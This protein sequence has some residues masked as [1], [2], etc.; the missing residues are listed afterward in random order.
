MFKGKSVLFCLVVALVG[1][2]VAVVDIVSSGIVD[3]TKSSARSGHLPA[4][5]SAPAGPCTITY[6]N[7]AAVITACPAGDGTALTGTD[8]ASDVQITVTVRDSNC[9][10][11]AGMPPEDIWLVGCNPDALLLCGASIC[12]SADHATDQ[13]GVTTISNS[14]RFGGCEP[15]GVLVVIAGTVVGPDDCL[16]LQIRSVDYKS[17]GGS[18]SPPPCGGDAQCPDGKVTNADFSWF[19]THYPTTTNPG[20]PYLACADYAVA[21]GTPISLAD[22]A[23]FTFHFAGV[24]HRCI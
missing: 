9:D 2:Q 8:T 12:C 7:N 4:L 16:P 3:A 18:G 11:I 19:V 13:D 1:S 24:G 17:A 20:A 14:P 22:F 6:P 21:Y 23:K 5:R 10:P 15:G